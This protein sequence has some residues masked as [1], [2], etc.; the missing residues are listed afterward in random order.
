MFEE[1]READVKAAFAETDRGVQRGEAAEAD[2]EGRNGR[3]R[4]DAAVLLFKDRDERGVHCGSRL[5]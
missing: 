4:T 1:I 2:I 5:T 3:T